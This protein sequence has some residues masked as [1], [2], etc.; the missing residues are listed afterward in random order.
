MARK[1]PDNRFARLVDSAT[2]V[3]IKQGYKRTQMG[4][5]AEALGVAKGTLYLYVES[6]EALFDLV[7]RCAD[8]TDA[9][10]VPDSLPVRTPAAGAMLAFAQARL[11][12]GGT[13]P[14]LAAAL[15]R[16]EVLDA[17]GEF[18]EIVRELYRTLSA[19]RTGIKLLD[20]AGRDFPELADLWF[21]TG[22]EGVLALLTEYFDDRIRRK[23]FRAVPDVS[24]AARLVLETTVFWAVHRHWD[25]RPQSVDETVSEETVVRF[26]VAA[27]AGE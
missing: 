13:L 20:A 26:V 3:F 22:R 5:V 23:L 7:V 11:A 6:K 1:I 2:S 4:D 10:S 27:F 14:A 16:E 25:P 12:E 21:Q 19:N 15:K 24:V 9:I 8:S 18:E 17:R